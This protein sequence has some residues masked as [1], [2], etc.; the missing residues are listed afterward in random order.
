MA[1]T[2]EAVNAI[3]DALEDV[4]RQIERAEKASN[5]RLSEV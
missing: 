1:E 3:G 4:G 5:K 2:Y